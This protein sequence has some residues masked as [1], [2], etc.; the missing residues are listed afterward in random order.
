MLADHLI[1]IEHILWLDVRLTTPAFLSLLTVR[2]SHSAI[3]AER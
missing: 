2:L 3:Y 1:Y